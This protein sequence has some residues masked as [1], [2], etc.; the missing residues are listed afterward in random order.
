MSFTLGGAVDGTYGSFGLR[1]FVAIEPPVVPKSYTGGDMG[2]R[3]VQTQR[4][5]L[6]VYK[7][8]IIEKPFDM[9]YYRKLKL[10]SKVEVE[11]DSVIRLFSNVAVEHDTDIVLHKDMKMEYSSALA[12]DSNIIAIA[13]ADITVARYTYSVYIANNTTLQKDVFVYE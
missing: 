13:E 1:P 9:E 4:M 3:D 7:P 5:E 10:C 8:L 11:N 2:S 6:N 12:Y